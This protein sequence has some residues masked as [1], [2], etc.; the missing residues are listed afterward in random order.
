[1]ALAAKLIEESPGAQGQLTQEDG[2]LIAELGLR[3]SR[4]L[5]QPSRDRGSAGPENDE[6]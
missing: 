3:F 6:W 2:L 1:M 5:V 4:R